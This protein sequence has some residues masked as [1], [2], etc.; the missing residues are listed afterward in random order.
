MKEILRISGV[1][2]EVVYYNPK[3]D[4]SVL[5]IATEGGENVTAVGIAP[6]VAEGEEIELGGS[7]VHHAEYGHQFSFISCSSSFF[8]EDPVKTSSAYRT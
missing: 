7:W 1:V 6:G 2:E 3:N 5:E 4:Y 8:A